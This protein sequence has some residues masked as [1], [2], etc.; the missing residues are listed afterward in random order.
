[1]KDKID[2]TIS[3]ARAMHGIC[4]MPSLQ[5]ILK[6]V[7]CVIANTT[8]L[9]STVGSMSDAQFRSRIH[10]HTTVYGYNLEY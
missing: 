1:M 2:E 8:A 3:D 6:L 5:I 4:E 9:T 7:K 10:V